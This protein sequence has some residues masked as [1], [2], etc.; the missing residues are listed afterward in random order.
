MLC[1]QQLTEI[2]RFCRQQEVIFKIGKAVIMLCVYVCVKKNKC[3]C[4]CVQVSQHVNRTAYFSL[5]SPQAFLLQSSYYIVLH[6]TS[7]PLPLFCL[8]HSLLNH[9]IPFTLF[10][11]PSF[12]F[13]FFSSFTV[14]SC[15]QPVLSPSL[16]FYSPTFSISFS[17]LLSD[18]CRNG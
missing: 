1:G 3:V 11:S 8:L 7:P 5:L 17:L 14:L 13:V 4:V 9:C 18:S 10:F 2:W 12:P 6:P 15:F 16:C